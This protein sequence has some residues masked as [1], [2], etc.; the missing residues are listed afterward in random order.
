MNNEV[1]AS[2]RRKR[3]TKNSQTSDPFPKFHI[4][5]LQ[6]GRSGFLLDVG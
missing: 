6:I 5:V 1:D 3:S 2:Q 4:V